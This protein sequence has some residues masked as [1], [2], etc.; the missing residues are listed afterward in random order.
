M[1]SSFICDIPLTFFNLVISDGL[2]E[3]D[4]SIS[5]IRATF[6]FMRSSPS[7]LTTFKRCAK[8]VSV[9]SKTVLTVDV[10]TRWNFTYLMLD[11]AEKFE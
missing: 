4:S 9:N 11:F 5:K 8:E 10:P 7:R 2:N 1:K 3:I 6:K